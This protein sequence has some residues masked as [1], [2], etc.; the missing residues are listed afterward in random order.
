MKGVAYHIGFFLVATVVAN[1]NLFGSLEGMSESLTKTGN[2]ERAMM[3]N[4]QP[5]MPE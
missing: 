5:P 2:L 3:A 4:Q 1:T